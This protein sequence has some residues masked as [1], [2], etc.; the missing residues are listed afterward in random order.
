MFCF[1]KRLSCLPETENQ[2]V[3]SEEHV[4]CELHRDAAKNQRPKTSKATTT[5]AAAAPAVAAAVLRVVSTL[6]QSRQG[7]QAYRHRAHSIV[8]SSAEIIPEHTV[9]RTCVVVRRP[10]DR[11][12]HHRRRFKKLQTMDVLCDLAWPH[13]LGTSR[14]TTAVT[15]LRN[16]LSCGDLFTRSGMPSNNKGAR[17]NPSEQTE[18]LDNVV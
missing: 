8:S 13:S 17:S 11:E 4:G 1:E 10:Q 14:Q 9:R 7:S 2:N 12:T 15:T 5:A 3:N 6:Q 16:V 18:R